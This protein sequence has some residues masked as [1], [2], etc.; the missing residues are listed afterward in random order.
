MTVTTTRPTTTPDYFEVPARTSGGL[1]RGLLL[2]CARTILQPLRNLQT[3]ER[4]TVN[5][6]PFSIAM[7]GRVG[8]KGANK[9]TTKRRLPEVPRGVPRS[10]PLQLC[11]EQ[12]IAVCH[13]GEIVPRTF[14]Y[15]I[16]SC[17]SLIPF[18]PIS[19]EECNT[20]PV[21]WFKIHQ[22]CAGHVAASC[23][24]IEIDVDALAVWRVA[25]RSEPFPPYGF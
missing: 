14:I 17:M 10:H 25:C 16:R 18:Y 20:I 7:Q 23:G 22:D 5:P 13:F 2:P 11:L 15:P 1:H 19:I 21:A 24:L 6:C 3:P 8:P 4:R 9:I 12:G